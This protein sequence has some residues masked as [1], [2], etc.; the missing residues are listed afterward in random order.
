MKTVIVVASARKEGHT[1]KIAATIAKISGWSVVDLH[2][3]TISPY[4]YE[5]KNSNDDF[6]RLMEKLIA[7]YDCFVFA[8]PVYWYAM[9]GMLK[10]FFDRFTDLLTIEKD[11][12]RKLR[13]KSMAAVSS[14]GGDHLEELFWM[15]F[16]KT[17]DYLG[18]NFIEGLHSNN[19]NASEQ[20]ISDFIRKVE[21]KA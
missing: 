12:G 7:N 19:G 8:T 2:D 14:S 18:M 3:Y 11:L 17:A 15:P 5:H 21:N 9:S 20:S 13:G 1:H 6:I 10:N 4:D 16:E